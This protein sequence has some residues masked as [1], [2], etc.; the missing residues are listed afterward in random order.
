MI[1]A[2]VAQGAGCRGMA[3]NMHWLWRAIAVGARFRSQQE[4]MTVTPKTTK[5]RLAAAVTA[6]LGLSACFPLG[7]A[8][9]GAGMVPGP[10]AVSTAPLPARSAN[11][12]TKELAVTEQVLDAN[13]TIK[14]MVPTI[15]GVGYAVVSVQPGKNLNQRRLLAIRVARLEAMR[16]LTAQIHGMRVD[17]STSVAEAVVQNDTLR[18]TVTGMIRG[19]RTAHIE[20]KGSDTYEVVLEVDRDMIAQMLKVARR[21][22]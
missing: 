12:A 18:A 19:A 20:P 16:D 7:G 21:A 4:S 6:C 10:G 1:H 22:G 3:R 2:K 11:P 8:P 17:S 5:A 9:M 13:D 14:A 15:T